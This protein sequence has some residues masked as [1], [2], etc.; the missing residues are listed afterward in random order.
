MWGGSAH[1]HPDVCLRKVTVIAQV[2]EAGPPG[3]AKAARPAATAAVH[4]QVHQVSRLAAST[5]SHTSDEVINLSVSRES[6]LQRF[7]SL[8]Q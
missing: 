7:V 2:E 6:Q 4:L 1:A 5:F 8:G 3:V